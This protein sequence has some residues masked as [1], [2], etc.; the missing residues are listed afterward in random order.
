M[1]KDSGQ[2]TVRAARIAGAL[3]L[4]LVVTSLSSFLYIGS[5][6]V[7]GDATSTANNILA[8]ETLFRL[9]IVVSLV[10]S[11]VFIFLARALYRLLSGVNEGYASL[12]VSFVLVSIPISFLGG[13]MQIAAVQ[14][15]HG[16]SFLSGFD[17]DL[18]RAL[19]MFFLN[20]ST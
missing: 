7:S 17:P 4:L 11:I 3:Y 10:S 8:S 14:L 20:L 9:A 18:L 1:M 19:A 12:M 6:I 2:P 13:L 16:A 15:L 5:L